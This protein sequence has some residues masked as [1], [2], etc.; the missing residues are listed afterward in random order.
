ML[1]NEITTRA[2]ALF[3]V[4]DGINSLLIKWGISPTLAEWLDEIISM[5]L[6]FLIAYGLDLIT[7]FILHKVVGKLV[8]FT[9]NKWDDIFV[10]EGVFRQI[11]HIFPAIVFYLSTPIALKSLFWINL[12]EKGALIYIVFV[13]IKAIHVASKAMSKAYSKSEDYANKPVQIIFQIISVLAFFIGAISLLSILL[14]TSFA[15]LFA[16]L[17]ASMAIIILVFKDTILGFVSGWQLSSNDM[18]RQGDWITVPKYGADGNVEEVSLYSVKVR[19]FDNTITTVPPYALVSESFQNWR[20]MQES[21]G[22]RIKRSIIIDMTSI[23]FCTPEMLDKFRKIQ[24][25]TEYIDST[26]EIIRNYNE[27]NKTDNSMLVNGRRQTNI[28]IF[29]AYIQKYIENH[30]EVNHEMTTMVR[31]L[32]PNEKGIP[33]ELYFFI[34]NKDWV[35]Y[36]NV[37]SD[38]FDHIMAV[39]TAFDLRVFQYPSSTGAPYTLYTE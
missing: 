20:G 6:L 31:Q 18:L 10:E 39:V 36:E 30:P 25:L 1:E 22:R 3:G 14:D 37:Q 35:Y 23:K 38:I 34:R 9:K 32:Q 12:F 17:G 28:G 15:T 29:R 11:A 5:S 33:L 26:E 13:I 2:T 27:K 7:R 21:G 24:Y 19:N 16:G 4:V 8:K